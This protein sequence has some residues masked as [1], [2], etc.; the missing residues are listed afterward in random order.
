MKNYDATDPDT[1]FV[2]CAVCEK[3]IMGDIAGLPASDT[4]TLPWPSA[5][6]SEP[7]P[8][9]NSRILTYRTFAQI[10]QNRSQ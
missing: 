6:R 5:A 2:L 8:L 7:R 4:R 9:R 1:A 3:D 10:D